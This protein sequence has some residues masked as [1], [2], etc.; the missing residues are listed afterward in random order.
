M[1]SLVTS[2]TPAA[3]AIRARQSSLTNSMKLASQEV[4]PAAAIAAAAEL[5]E[6]QEKLAV[7][8]CLM[9]D[10]AA[11]MSARSGRTSNCNRTSQSWI[12]Y[13]ATSGHCMVMFGG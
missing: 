12:A 5:H 3:D 8:A 13:L 11:I 1:G 6:L 10:P 9:C 4:S 2:A 7:C